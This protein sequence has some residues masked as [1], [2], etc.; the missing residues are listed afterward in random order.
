[1]YVVDFLTATS[2]MKL[3]NE[4]FHDMNQEWD[5]KH[6]RQIRKYL[7][8]IFY[9]AKDSIQVNEMLYSVELSRMAK[10]EDSKS[11]LTP[12]TTL[13][14]PQKEDNHKKFNNS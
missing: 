5:V 3:R 13:F 9:V 10:M 1:M 6:L 4:L 2:D 12:I 8:M 7:R 14:T 11:I